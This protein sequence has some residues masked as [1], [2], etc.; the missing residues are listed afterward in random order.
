MGVTIRDAL[1]AKAYADWVGSVEDRLAGWRTE[2]LGLATG[3]DD[4]TA[5]AAEL[6]AG[7]YP[8]LNPA[9][10]EGGN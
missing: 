1:A 3:L 4:G 10:P 7:W 5:P 2:H 6:A 8:E 9:P